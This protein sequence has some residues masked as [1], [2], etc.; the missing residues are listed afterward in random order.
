MAVTASNL[1]GL[2]HC[3][4][5]V[6]EEPDAHRETEDVFPAHR[7]PQ[8]L[9]QRRVYTTAI[10]NRK[11]VAARKRTSI[12]RFS[13]ASQLDEQAQREAVLRLHEVGREPRHEG[14]RRARVASRR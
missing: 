6:P 12:M 5:Q 14:S 10:Q 4:Q 8:T 2:E 11:T 1:F 9:S 7:V 3:P 13:P